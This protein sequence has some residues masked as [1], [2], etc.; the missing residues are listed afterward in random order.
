ME[1][2]DP[3]MLQAFVPVVRG[4][5]L[6]RQGALRTAGTSWHGAD[7]VRS[8]AEGVAVPGGRVACEHHRKEE[9]SQAVKD[10]SK[11]NFGFRVKLK[12]GSSPSDKE[13]EHTLMNIDIEKLTGLIK[14]LKLEGAADK[15]GIPNALFRRDTT[16]WAYY[17][18]LLFNDLQGTM[19][20]PDTWKGSIFHLIYITGNP[21]APSNSLD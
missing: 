13:Q 10:P 12:T 1:Y 21:A 16:F 14:K 15:N 7:E 11:I 19:R 8:A 17:L 9:A 2:V 5:V 18:A 6:T 20:L 4:K 3:F